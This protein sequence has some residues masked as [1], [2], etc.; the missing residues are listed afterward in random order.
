MDH[1]LAQLATQMAHSGSS[2]N[3]TQ[4]SEADEALLLQLFG[5]YGQPLSVRIFR[6]NQN[7]NKSPFAFVKM[8]S[9]NEA[10]ASIT[11]LNGAQLGSNVIEVKFADSDLGV[12][13]PERS[14]PPSD[15]L[16]VKNLPPTFGDEELRQLFSPFGLVTMCRVLH[17]GDQTGQGGAALVRM[18]TLDEAARSIQGLQGQRVLGAVQPLVVRFADTAE[19]KARKQAK[20]V[21]AAISASAVQQQHLLLSHQRYAGTAYPGGLATMGTAAT[22]LSHIMHQP[23]TLAAGPGSQAATAAYFT[24]PVASSAG[25]LAV[26]AA[27]MPL[28]AHP[29]TYGAAQAHDGTGGL[30]ITDPSS[31]YALAAAPTG[32]S[33]GMHAAASASPLMMPAAAGGA[34]SLALPAASLPVAS[35]YVRNLPP[36]ADKVFLYEKFSPFGAILSVKVLT[37]E[38]G[39]SKGVG[40]VNFSDAVGAAKAVAALHNLPVGDRNLHV[41]FQTHRKV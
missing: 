9:V 34:A 3:P 39:A 33:R 31:T 14:P 29:G 17:Q 2:A 10:E 28:A 23:I 13:N 21:G 18:S 32:S 8:A 24:T 25:T 27:G 11:S 26:G 1:Q 16:Y 37:D 35:L 15:N 5:N 4:H 38:G 20:Q 40:F 6:S 30:Y 41:A 19:I 22:S 7:P 12:A 36:E